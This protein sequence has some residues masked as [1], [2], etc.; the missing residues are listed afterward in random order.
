MQGSENQFDV[1]IS[2]L[3]LKHPLTSTTSEGQRENFK[4]RSWGNGLFG[5]FC[6]G[7][8][9]VP[10]DGMYLA[11]KDQ[12]IGSKKY[13]KMSPKNFSRKKLL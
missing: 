9:E 11:K 1:T 4:K 2:K 3:N 12:N 8:P 13:H 5:Q 6:F 7:L 10:D